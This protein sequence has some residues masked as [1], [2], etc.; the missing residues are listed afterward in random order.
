MFNSTP[1]AYRLLVLLSVATLAACS[2]VGPNYEA[3]QLEGVPS[4][5][6]QSTLQTQPSDA[7]AMRTWWQAFQ[8]PM[9]DQLVQ[10]ALAENQDLGIA[11]ARLQQARAERIQVA[12]GQLPHV[13]L[14]AGGEATRS[15][16]EIQ[17][18]SGGRSHAW[19]AGF[20]AS[21]ELDVFG[22]TRRA[23]ESADAQID[24]L[25]ADRHALQ[26]SLL[27]ELAASYA[28][29]RTTQE[30]LLIAQDNIRNLQESEQL[31][32]RALNRGLGTEVEF[33]QA[34]AEREYA[35]AQ[36]PVFQADIAKL[37]HAIGVLV[38]GFPA[39]WDAPLAQPSRSLLRVPALPL[40]LPSDVIR[41]RPDLQAAER[42][43]AAAT[44]DIGVAEA[45]RF[46]HFRIPL[47]LGTAASVIHDLFSSAS[48]LWSVGLQASQ[49]LYDGGRA[50]AGVV[51][52]QAQAQAARLA[53]ERDV[54]LAL[55]DV[56]DALSSLHSERQRQV[57][58][59]AAAQDSQQALD[60]ATQLY[61]QGLSAYLPVLIAQRAANQA[62][63]A[64]AV[65]RYGEVRGAIALYKSLGAG[66]QPDTE[67]GDATEQP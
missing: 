52:A 38:G 67:Q 29:L 63:D 16:K 4:R 22:G 66:W 27:A 1:F 49:N 14:G 13:G 17:G 43:L 30:R 19:R 8:D 48:L 5:W 42:R 15:S 51:A 44:A 10:R 37:S 9:L 11:L 3:P 25:R 61:C 20:D 12:A 24:A 59:S 33:L 58:L 50:E 21:W 56:E 36:P 7:Q 65:S 47:G 31:A 45:E 46:P 32:Q 60:R 28:E 40:D 41:Q 55:R 2:T 57:A 54:R 35:E 53:Y 6:S 18:A 64:L 34:R 39:D 62:R 23:I 26:V